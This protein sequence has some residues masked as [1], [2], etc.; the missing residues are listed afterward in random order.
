MYGVIKVST[1][2]RFGVS[3][4]IGIASKLDELVSI[5]GQDRSSVV[6]RAVEEYVHED[7]HVGEEHHCSGILIYKDKQ[8][9]GNLGDKTSSSIIKGISFIQLRGGSVTVFFVEGSYS[10]I[11]LVRR[12]LSEMGGSMR[13]IPINCSLEGVK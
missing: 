13:Y 1:K 4:P 11:Q 9:P 6:A 8:P 3:I 5:T 12:K 10:S 7:L 2:K